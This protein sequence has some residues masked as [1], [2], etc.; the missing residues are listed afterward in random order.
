MSK[1][2]QKCFQKLRMLGPE[3]HFRS[4]QI[5]K[6]KVL[7]VFPINIQFIKLYKSCK[8]M[9]TGSWKVGRHIVPQLSQ[10]KLNQ[11]KQ[12]FRNP[13]DKQ[14]S[15]LSLGFK[16][17]QDFTQKE[18]KNHHC[19]VKVAHCMMIILSKNRSLFSGLVLVVCSSKRW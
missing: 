10:P 12:V 3:N 9:R 2:E 1:F 11:I 8:F 7:G 6:M 15:K 19:K 13:H 4:L 14:I 16:F 17:D 18:G 5:I